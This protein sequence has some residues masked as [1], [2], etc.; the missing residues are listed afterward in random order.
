M[1]R[2]RTINASGNLSLSLVMLGTALVLVA[3][4]TAPTTR[5]GPVDPSAS[6]AATTSTGTAVTTPASAFDFPK[7]RDVPASRVLVRDGRV[8]LDGVDTG[9]RTTASR[10]NVLAVGA[11][12]FWIYARVGS[13]AA[14][15]ASFLWI[16]PTQTLKPLGTFAGRELE[17]GSFA[18]ER[19]DSHGVTVEIAQLAGDR[20]KTL[21]R[22]ES[23]NVSVSFVSGSREEVVLL[24]ARVGTAGPGSSGGRQPGTL[25][26]PIRAGGPGPVGTVEVIT[27]RP[28]REPARKVHEAKG[29][30]LL[31]QTLGT[32][33]RGRVLL[34]E[35]THGRMTPAPAGVTPPKLGL[36]VLDLASGKITELGRFRAGWLP[37][38]AAYI[39]LHATWSPLSV[40][41]SGFDCHHVVRADLTVESHCPGAT[42]QNS[43]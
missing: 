36:A 25:G 40:A 9:V 34:Q 10:V 5:Q 35:A 19:R 20:V 31:D 17:D 18:L 24:A 2:L 37:M 4:N 41:A 38:G 27:L 16:K 42:A 30:R 12:R 13:S 1:P 43:P 32:V 22:R 3:C 26:K 7:A 21:W 8:L 39:T 15:Y 6:A 23:R 28:N 14:D 29:Y 11:G 33:Y